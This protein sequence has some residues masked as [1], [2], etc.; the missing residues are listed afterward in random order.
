MNGGILWAKITFG[1]FISTSAIL[2]T[3]HN[4]FTFNR[5]KQPKKHAVTPSYRNQHAEGVSSLNGD[6]P[7]SENGAVLKAYAIE[8]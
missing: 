8:F 3:A 2:Q 5:Y 1:I 7:W 6:T 4:L